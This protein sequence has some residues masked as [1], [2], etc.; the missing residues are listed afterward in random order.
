M[1]KKII[2]MLFAMMLSLSVG[3]ICHASSFEPTIDAANGKVGD[4]I[5]VNV[6]IP[7][8]TTAVGGSFNLVYDNTKMELIDAVA[9]SL[10]TDRT[11]TV[12]KTYA[13]NKIRL[14]FAGTTNIS[15]SGGTALTATF[16]LTAEGTANLATEKFK[17]M[18]IDT[19]SLDCQND[20]YTVTI[21]TPITE[22]VASPTAS[23]TSTNVISGTSVQLSTT[24]NGADIYYTTDGSTP[25]TSSTK[26]TNAITITEDV[27][28][29][30]VA[31]KADMENSD[32]VT[33]T[34]TVINS[35]SPL[36]EVS[37]AKGKAGQNIDV[38]I[39]L[40][41]NPGI[42]SMMLSLSYDNSYLTLTDV[43]DAGV[44]GSAMHSDAYITV[45]YTLSWANDTATSNFMVNGNI[46]TLT[47]KVADDAPE[48]DIPIVI[49]YNNSHY[50]IYNVD[51]QTVDFGITNGG[52]TVTKY[53]VGDVNGDG[54]VNSLDRATLARYLANWTGYA[55]KVVLEAADV[56]GDGSVNSLDRAI[57]SRHLAKWSGYETLPY[58]K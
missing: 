48:G 28:I 41:N 32:V 37:T 18:D 49:N 27:T 46:V 51:L 43:K 45:P 3:V 10:V 6:S 25:T 22:K 26:Y 33:F 36:I 15:A 9:G 17:L 42:I 24:T 44:L 56:N 8:G 16:K 50:D 7:G 40:A 47:F 30:A 13:A 11:Y 35:D 58:I 23:I 52:I 14:N 19:N 29:K 4:T 20:T 2:T 57:L 53:I 54:S 12:N 38:T 31:I 55:E 39:S 34:Y 1:K 21:V 5:S